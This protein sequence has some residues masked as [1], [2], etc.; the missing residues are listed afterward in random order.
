[1]EVKAEA[2][3]HSGFTHSSAN[4]LKPYSD[5]L[6]YCNFP[7][8]LCTSSA[9]A[10][11][12]YFSGAPLNFSCLLFIFC[13]T[14]FIYNLDHL[15]PSKSDRINS[16]ERSKWITKNTSL[17]KSSICFYFVICAIV[18]AFN[19][20]SKIYLTAFSLLALCTLYK[21]KLRKLPAMKN[22]TVAVV[23]TITVAAL[24]C[25]WLNAAPYTPFFG[26]CF[27]TALINT[28]IFDIRDLYGD[29]LEGV[30]SIPALCGEKNSSKTIYILCALTF[31]YSFT[32]LPTALT[33]VPLLLAIIHK[34][35]NSKLKY[36]MADL[37][38][39]WPLVLTIF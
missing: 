20:Q 2:G 34:W 39:A 28:V 14:A 5:F 9:A 26:F 11:A 25:I 32:F 17:L 38:L 7:V 23:W 1:M 35:E 30:K 29:Q 22:F 18:L 19:P 13:A 6:I 27:L 31:I 12:Y 16:P 37:I 24:P 33:A 21:G 3:E 36:L 10:G 4:L 8:A 15:N